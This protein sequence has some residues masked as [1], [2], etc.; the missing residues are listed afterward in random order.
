MDYD[1][2]CE[3]TDDDSQ[4][5]TEPRKR[6]TRRDAGVL[7]SGNGMR[8]VSGI[9]IAIAGSWFLWNAP[10]T[11]GNLLGAGVIFLLL[12]LLIRD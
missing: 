5:L 11:S 12:C 1:K 10:W 4:V 3:L 6:F 7:D 9:L 2:F 8:T